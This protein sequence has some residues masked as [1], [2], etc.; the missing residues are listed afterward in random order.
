MVRAA[1]LIDPMPMQRIRDICDYH[2]SVEQAAATA[3]RAG[4]P[5]AEI[6]TD[7][8]GVDTGDRLAALA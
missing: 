7:V 2:S 8:Q 3:T 4:V 6:T 1:A 5:S